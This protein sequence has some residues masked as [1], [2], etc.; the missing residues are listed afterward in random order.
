MFYILDQ[1][2]IAIQIQNKVRHGLVTVILNFEINL[3][4]ME[5]DAP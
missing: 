4:Y 5:V 3:L 2:E 1:V